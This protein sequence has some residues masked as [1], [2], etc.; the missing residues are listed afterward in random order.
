[1]Q[2]PTLSNETSGQIKNLENI[3]MV[4]NWLK[5]NVSVTT[6]CIKRY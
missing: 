1:M 2:V 5:N 6:Q 3:L 4:E